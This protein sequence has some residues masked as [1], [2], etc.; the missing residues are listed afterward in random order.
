VRL[1]QG[2]VAEP[3]RALGRRPCRGA[4]EKD[5]QTKE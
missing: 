1:S 3:G 4:A 5:R 2:G